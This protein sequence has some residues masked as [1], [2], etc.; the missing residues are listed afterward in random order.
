ML[1]A[2]CGTP[3]A[4]IERALAAQGQMPAVR[5]AALRRRRDV[6]RLH[7]RRA[8]RPAPRER[9]RA[10]RLRARRALVDGRGRELAFGG[11]VMKNVA[12]YDVSRLIAGSL[13]TLGVIAEASIKVLPLPAAETTL[14]LEASEGAALELFNALGRPAAPGVRHGVARRRGVRSSLGKRGGAA[15]CRGAGRRRAAGG[16]RG[17]RAVARDPR[18]PAR[19]LRRGRAALAPRR[20]GDR[21]AA[22]AGGPPADRVGRCAALAQVARRSRRDP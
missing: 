15:Q 5:A 16:R 7:C 4:E 6:R 3:L 18:A 20:A 12:G 9:R 19:V 1:T 11:Q 17:G 10:A 8:F 14:R 2:R 22:R 21:G 13:G